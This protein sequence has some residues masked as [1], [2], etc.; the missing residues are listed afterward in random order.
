MS[1]GSQNTHTW[2]SVAALCGSPKEEVIQMPV[3]VERKKKKI[4]ATIPDHNFHSM[5]E[6]TILCYS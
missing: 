1:V 3:T 2:I 5:G 6:P 4:L